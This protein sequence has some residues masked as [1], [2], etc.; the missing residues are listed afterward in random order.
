MHNLLHVATAAIAAVAFISASLP[1]MSDGR[2]DVYGRFYPE[3]NDDLSYEN[4]VVAFRI[5]GPATQ[6]H[7]E[8]SFGY[9]IFVKYPG[10]GLVLPYLYGEQC[11]A[12]NWA[13]VDSLRKIDKTMAKEFEKSFTY[14]IDHGRGADCY[15]VGPTLG[16][17]VAA[18]LDEEG[19]IQFPWCYE[20]AEI[21]DNGPDRFEALLS[22]APVMIG[23][24][25]ITERRR[26][27]LEKGSYLN[28]CEVTYD[29][30]SH[31]YSLVVGVPRRDEGAAL[32]DAASGVVAYEDPTQRSDSGKI[33][34]GIVI[35]GGANE[36]IE[37]QGHILAKSIV[38]PGETFRYYWGNAWSKG[39]MT[40]FDEWVGYLNG[41][42]SSQGD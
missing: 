33:F 4:D 17:G 29:G 11:S 9:D 38:E 2:G 35:P 12:S 36:M 30:L 23:Q 22:F 8:K 37:D 19:M 7:G 21:V 18:L 13:K 41:F 1:A 14:H 16:C 31:P 6:K 28:S 34:T 39:K 10:A 42:L 5:Y 40:T 32:M 26:I 3:R 25:T 20:T 24:D 27:V 15:A